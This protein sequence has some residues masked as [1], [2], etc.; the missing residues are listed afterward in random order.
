MTSQRKYWKI[1][2]TLVKGIHVNKGEMCVLY[3]S[4]KIDLILKFIEIDEAFVNLLH[5]YSKLGCHK[6]HKFQ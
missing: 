4:H 3:T 6:L 2:F 5:N 1:P